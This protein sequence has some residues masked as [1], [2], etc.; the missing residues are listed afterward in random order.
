M[1]IAIM[2]DTH[3]REREIEVPDADTVIHCGDFSMLGQV[4]ELVTFLNWFG[5]LPH[6][7]KILVAGNHDRILEHNREGAQHWIDLVSREFGQIHYLQDSELVLDGIRFYGSP[8]VPRFGGW[9][10]MLD[11]E[12]LQNVWARVPDDV[13]VLITHGPPKD[14]L[15]LSPYG[16]EHAGDVELLA[17]V[18]QLKN[19]KLHCFGHIHDGS[20]MVE[21]GTLR[22]DA[23]K[24]LQR[25]WMVNA[26]ICDE[27]YNPTNPVRLVEI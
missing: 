2:S 14:I 11:R 19:L 16:N 18:M 21:I 25:T 5:Q 22:A 6:K 12:G 26:A 8:W 20:G 17:K 24:A 13:E 1:K 27:K 23:P 10:F 3:G 9:S 4:S 15:D 7:N